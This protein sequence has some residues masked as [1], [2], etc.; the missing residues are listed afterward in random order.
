MYIAY[1]SFQ[2]ILVLQTGFHLI[3]QHNAMYGEILGPEVEAYS[4][5]REEAGIYIS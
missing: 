1:I 2:Q 4:Q 5:L 3:M